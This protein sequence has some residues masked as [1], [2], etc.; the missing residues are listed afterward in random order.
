MPRPWP[1]RR[2]R[3]AREGYAVAL[4]ARRPGPLDALAKDLTRVG[5]TA[6]AIAADLSDTAAVPALAEQIRAQ[7]GN[8]DALYYAPTP[9]A[10][11]GLFVPAS[12][13]TPQRAE[14]SM[15][16][17]VYTLVALVQQFLPHMIEHGDGAILTAQGASA[18]HGM[19]NM[20]GPGLAQAAQRNYLQS[21]DA[22][23]ADKGVYIG[24]LYIGAAIKNTSFHAAME[25]AN[26]G[27]KPG[28][29]MATVD[30]ADLADLLWTMHS[31]KSPPEATYPEGVFDR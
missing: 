30:P 21:L 1:G 5:A 14:A 2:P 17:A 24:R 23:V 8:L 29:E 13:V 3:F 20:S 25:A 27:G 10:Y 4:V 22:E 9:A 11:D 31:V 26:A 16:L 28:P 12:N 6:S 15:P 19:A 18:V 7:V